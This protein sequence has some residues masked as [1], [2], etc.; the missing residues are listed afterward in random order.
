MSRLVGKTLLRLGMR[1]SLIRHFLAGSDAPRDL[2]DTFAATV[3]GVSPDVLR[4][5][6][7]AIL[8]VDARDALR[9]C[10]MP[11]IYLAATRDRLVGKRAR[12][13]L[14]AVRADVPVV[15]IDSPHLLLQ[16]QPAAAAHAVANFCR[17]VA[18]VQL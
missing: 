1:R 5:R 2:V 16:R 6:V 12:E 10:R 9:E 4:A 3:A 14:L 13:A 7:Q 17:S 11:I 18:G 8:S 15:Q